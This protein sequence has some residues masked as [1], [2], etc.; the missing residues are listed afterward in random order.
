MVCCVTLC[1]DMLCYVC[2]CMDVDVC[3]WVGVVWGGESTLLKT[4]V[5]RM[6]LSICS[7]TYSH[8]PREC[9]NFIW[10]TETQLLWGKHPGLLQSVATSHL[11]GCTIV[12][13]GVRMK[14]SGQPRPPL[15]VPLNSISWQ[16][17]PPCQ[18]A[19]ALDDP[20]ALPCV[21]CRTRRA[22]LFG[23][24]QKGATEFGTLSASFSPRP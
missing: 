6:R 23:A 19:D 3:I 4:K 11:C 9:C 7:R 2:M 12:A 14:T 18:T 13:V 1:Y 15:L 8:T 16:E 21:L 22:P 17:R 24:T 20:G 10:I 5:L